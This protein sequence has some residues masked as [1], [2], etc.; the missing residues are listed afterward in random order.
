MS[1]LQ[2]IAAVLSAAWT[3]ISTVI[4]LTPTKR[5]D[6]WLA[7]WQPRARA[8]FERIS[9]LQPKTSPG[10]FSLPGKPAAPPKE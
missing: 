6:E 4:A 5:D 7:S 3:F 2:A 9:F 8:F 10:V 1:T